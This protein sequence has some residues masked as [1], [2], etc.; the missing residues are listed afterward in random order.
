M[1]LRITTRWVTASAAAALLLMPANAYAESP[2]PTPTNET[3]RTA[4]PATGTPS[5]LES[6]TPASTP[7]TDPDSAT[8][9][10][11]TPDPSAS[12]P[13]V[14]SSPRPGATDTPA[15]PRTE[16]SQTPSLREQA[17]QAPAPPQVT[18]AIT[19]GGTPQAGKFFE[20]IGYYAIRGTVSSGAGVAVGIYWYDAPAKVWRQSKSVTTAAGGAYAVNQ[21]VGHAATI[22]FRATLGGAPGKPGVTSSNEVKVSVQNS[23]ITETKPVASIN[24]LKNPTI[25]GSIYP[26][27][28]GVWI[29]IQVQAPN[30]GYLTATSAR[31]D[32]A[33]KY[34]AVLGYGNGTLK[35]Y[36]TRTAYY[37]TNRPRYEI[38]KVYPIKRAKVLDA[39]ITKTTSAEVAKTYRSG[40]PVGPSK[41]R[42]IKMNYFGFD[43]KLHRGVIIVRTDLTAKIRRGFQEALDAGFPIARMQNPN[44]F[45]GNDPKQME[46]NNTSGFNCRKV[47]GNPYAQ[48]PHSYGI[49]IDVDTVQ[50]PYRDRNGKWWPK[51]GR[52]YIDRTP[53]QFGMLTKGSHLT[54]QLK[55]EGYFW[56]GLWSPGKDYQHYEYDK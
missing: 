15:A 45:G 21:N 50:N 8:T 30:K 54:K 40:C 12:T 20:D 4:A 7:P 38:S 13:S 47:V 11:A 49:A 46:A 44:D 34:R 52:K 53:R 29:S 5:P 41:L 43:K 3:A 9:A 17:E 14:E 36:N 32:A 42:T 19:A 2:T 51:N 16:S 26:A 48:S 24:A 1:G 55:K 37:A 28:K 18:L 56:G 35:T 27:R 39:V 25:S 10:S 33:G 22:A 6:S 31:T 23:S